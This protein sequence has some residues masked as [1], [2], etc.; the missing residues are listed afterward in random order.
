MAEIIWK[1]KSSREIEG[2]I[3]TNTPP[4]TKPKMRVDKIEIDGRDGD[5]IEKVG[6]ESYDKNVG[7]GITRNYDINEVIKY[8]TGDGELTLSDEPD[9]VYIASIFDD[10]DYDRL[11]QIRKATV[12]FHVQPFKYL[13]NESKVSLNVTTQTSVEVEN[14]GLE[15]SKPIIL[16]EGSGTIEIAVNGV[17]I[18]KY[19][20]PSGE[21][22]VIINSLEEEAYFEGIYKNRNMLG[23]FP[24]LQVG[25]NTIS[26]TGTLTKIEIEPK[27]RWL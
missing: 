24:K 26:W 15:V 19:T 5:I 16:L 8:F 9:K 3:I 1:N 10:V 17:N 12:K 18:F 11:L 25:I 13:K 6:Y 22:K 2:L 20:F 4:I 21:T 14:K 7:I 23:E 27:S